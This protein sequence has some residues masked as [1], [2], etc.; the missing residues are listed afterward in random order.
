MKLGEPEELKLTQIEEGTRSV[1]VDFIHTDEGLTMSWQGIELPREEFFKFLDGLKRIIGMRAAMLSHP[2]TGIWRVDEA[3]LK[4][5]GK[6]QDATRPLIEG[7][8]QGYFGVGSVEVTVSDA[9]T[10]APIS[11]P[12]SAVGGP[13]W[14]QRQAEGLR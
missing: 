6:T 10:P 5:Y 11:S 1:V 7:Y 4:A 9:R 3:S 2:Q 13:S 12:P 8:I 14:R